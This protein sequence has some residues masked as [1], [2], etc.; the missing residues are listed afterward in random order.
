MYPFIS[1]EHHSNSWNAKL[2]LHHSHHMHHW[3]NCSDMFDPVLWRQTSRPLLSGTLVS[4]R[5]LLMGIRAH[6]SQ[7]DSVTL[8]PLVCICELSSCGLEG[9]LCRSGHGSER[10]EYVVVGSICGRLLKSFKMISSLM[11]WE[12]E[13][14]F[15]HPDCSTVVAFNT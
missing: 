2:S 3:H 9:A 6:W 12:M 14:S 5:L 13:V 7:L 11:A 4:H 8:P 1:G 15:S 10:D